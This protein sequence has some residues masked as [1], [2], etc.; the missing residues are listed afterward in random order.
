MRALVRT[1]IVL[2]LGLLLAL[3][4]AAREEIRSYNSNVVLAASGDVTVTET[5]VV[6][7]EGVEI[8]RGIYRDIPV[9]MLTSDGGKLRPELNVLSVQRDGR[10]ETFR[11][12]RMGNFERIWIGNPDVLLNDGPH[13]YVITYTMSRMAR[14]FDDHDELYWNVTGNYWIFPILSAQASVTLPDGAV[15]TNLAGYTGALG[16]TEQAVVSKRNSD[17][18]ASFRATRALDAGEGLTIAVAFNK[19]VIVYPTGMA[20]LLQQIADLRDTIIPVLAALLAVAYNGLAWY[21]VGRDPAKGTIIPLF[22]APKGFSPALVHYVNKW[23]FANSGWT[24]LTAAIFNLGVKGLV[25]I[26]NSADKLKI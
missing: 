9:V 25:S 22:H 2:L 21:R 26:D 18:T 1:S 6:N 16:S 24:A 11:Q 10:D 4:A 7:A 13:R 5:L 12:E 8:R 19:G 23:G 17:S 20:A 14:S 3:P 15:I